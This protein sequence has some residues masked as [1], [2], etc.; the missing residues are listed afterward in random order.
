MA[1]TCINGGECDGCME[2]QAEDPVLYDYETEPIYAGDTYYEI[3]G[4][5]VSE[6]GL[7]D[8]CDQF[9][10]IAQRVGE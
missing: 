1:M 10:R 6:D 4:D 7:H 9:K 5:I 3:M 8:Y 2:C